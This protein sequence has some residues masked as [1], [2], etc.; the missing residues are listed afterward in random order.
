MTICLTCNRYFMDAE[1]CTA[2]GIRYPDG[3]VIEAVPYGNKSTE[4]S[5][6]HCPQCGVDE[7]G[8]IIWDARSRRVR[9]A[10][11]HLSAVGV[12]Q[13]GEFNRI[14]ANLHWLFSRLELL[15]ITVSPCQPLQSG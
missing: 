8:T 3:S 9:D 10:V 15:G 14:D 2:D 13:M 11:R 5:S 4:E 12:C 6:S 1:S 7:G